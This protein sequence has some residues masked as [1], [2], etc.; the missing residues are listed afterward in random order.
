MRRRAAVAAI[1]VLA[2]VVMTHPALAATQAVGSINTTDSEFRNAT[3]LTNT[4]VA[5]SGQSANV[6][7]ANVASSSG[8]FFDGFEDESADAGVAD[9]FTTNSGD[10]SLSVTRTNSYSGA[11][12]YLVDG[13]SAGG[14]LVTTPSYQ[15]L[16]SSNDE[17]ITFVL[18]GEQGV[19]AGVQLEESSVEI[20][21]LNIRNGDLQNYDNGYTTI[22]SDVD[23]GEHVRITLSDLEDGSTYRL[24]Y[25]TSEG[26]TGTLTPNFRNTPSG[27]W[28]TFR[29][30]SYEGKMF[31]DDITF[32][33]YSRSLAD[34]GTYIS[35]V[36]DVGNAST[37]FVNL[38]LDNADAN[39][40]WEGYNGNSWVQVAQT[41]YQSGGNKTDS[42]SGGYEKWRVNVTLHQTAGAT[43]AKVH[44]DGVIFSNGA[45]T[46]DNSTLDPPDGAELDNDEVQYSAQINDSTFGTPQGDRVNASLYIDGTYRGSDIL[47]SNGT[48]AVNASGL[49]G[50]SHTYHFELEDNYTATGA[51]Q[52]NT[53]NVPST[54]YIRN[55]SNITELVT[56]PTEVTVR[57]FEEDNAT[58]V[59][60]TTTTGKVSL[61]GLDASRSYIVSARADG[62]QD[63]RVVITSLYDAQSVYL[64][65]NSRDAANITFRLEDNVGRYPAQSTRLFIDKAIN[66]SSTGKTKFRTVAGDVFGASGGFPVSLEDNRRYR[67]RVVNQDGDERVL[68]AYETRG[69]A[70]EILTIGSV[71]LR[72]DSSGDGAFT[73]ELDSSGSRAV[74]IRYADP[75]DSTSQVRVTI[76]RYGNASNVLVDNQTFNGT[77]GT[78]TASFPV[79]PS[80]PDDVS[81]EVDYV[82]VTDE[83]Q[84]NGTAIV[85]AVP[86]VA[87]Q[88]G[89]APNVLS[90]FG[91]GTIIIVTGLVA[92]A[93]PELATVVA[94]TVAT[95]M[96]YIGAVAI[97]LPL[98]GVAG[99]IAFVSNAG[100]LRS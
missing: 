36:H 5:G 88:L 27:G 17:N 18:H 10:G 81:Y 67:L 23:A 47:T 78:L 6:S 25:Q 7:L 58:V 75:N 91:W 45:P 42:L 57:F 41:D 86:P 70:V 73:A 15:P 74:R 71:L 89:L 8:S 90:L 92:I 62:W 72:G 39:V 80:A 35:D 76:H 82:A 98:L 28:T 93:S 21:R 34:S 30:A 2:V 33:D 85:G 50:G 55:E 53:V 37:G 77:Y 49:N 87:Q 38:T 31:F 84:Q 9:N 68:G 24:E 11:N 59:E 32:G 12:S 26:D 14:S 44:D 99:A 51:S 29:L 96:T 97:P 60:R 4:T 61:N 64:L 94:T 95:L 69:D 19:N 65:N 48:A 52:T 79:P 43:T 16:G 40:T 54:L 83:G 56:S 22:A 66:N 100:R 46:V 20:L 63:R 13:A 1:M 3:E